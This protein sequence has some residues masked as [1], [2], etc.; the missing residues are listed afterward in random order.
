MRDRSRTS[1]FA[2]LKAAWH[3]LQ[4]SI[5]VGDRLNENLKSMTFVS[6]FTG[7]LGLAL[8]ISNLVFS[9]LPL[10]DTR[11]LMSFVTLFAGAGCAFCCKVLKRRE[12]AILIPTMFCIIVFTVYA[13]TG[14]AEGT[15]ILWSLMLPIGMC[16]FIS[17]KLGILLSG[18]YSLLY[19]VLFYTPLGASTAQYYTDA[20]MQRFPL[21]FFSLSVFTAIAMVQYHR[22]VLLEIDYTSRLNAEVAKQTAVAEERA[23]KI[24]E[25]SFQTIQ[26]LANAI[27]AKDPYTKG[28]STRV[29]QYSVRIAE[30]LGWDPDRVSN[31]RYAALLHDIGKIGVPDSI[32]NN[33]KRLTDV[34][35]D[36]IKS[37]TTMGAEILRDRTMIRPAENV[38]RSHHERYDGKGYPDGLAGTAISEEARIVAIADAFDAMSSNRIYRKACDRDYISGELEKGKGTQ[39]DPEYAEVFLNLWN[40]GEL[41]DILKKDAADS[42]EKAGVSS[43]LLQEVVE[44][45]ASQSAA[46]SIDIAT[47]VMSRSAGEGAIANRMQQ[48][49]GCFIFF[50]MDN[51]KK[52]NDTH[53]HDAGDKVLRLMGDMLNQNGED[54]L[55]CRLGG[56]EFL[57][58][59]PGVSSEAAESRVRKI[60][61]SFNE[62]KVRDAH[63]AIATLSAGMVMTS[64]ADTYLTAYNHADK[65]LYHVKQNGKNGYSFYNDENE[66]DTTD[67]NRI[68]PG[69]RASGS[70]DGGLDVDYRHF[71]RLYDFIENLEKRFSQPFKLV[72]IT[73]EP[74]DGSAPHTDEQEKAMYYMEQAIRQTVRGVDVLTR[75]SSR[76]YLVIL[77]GAKP[78]GVKIAVD[79]MFRGYY[80]MNGSGAFSPSYTVADPEEAKK[81]DTL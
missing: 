60:I 35:Y 57:L 75:Y 44:A 50:D 25:M 11:V 4:Q 1:V 47:G 38:A 27:D 34:E 41:D 21:A 67:V 78:E 73:L 39:F 26:T 30:S 62:N 18:Y 8:L 43:S 14:Y 40:R 66:I 61:S 31:L 24:E 28:H 80:K 45:F 49:A 70:Y 52:I 3:D 69:I 72:L 36:I 56:D 2:P 12:I 54:G 16:Y 9:R 19:F 64:P 13:F 22:Y 10:G 20:F 68:V 59:L 46:D 6:L 32:L 15:G 81:R 74:A 5:Y 53:G 17:V 7:V 77:V 48:E 51:L 37:H 42:G 23:R 65:A 79:R 29:S 33:P 71:A 76:Q 55:R 63:I 58:F